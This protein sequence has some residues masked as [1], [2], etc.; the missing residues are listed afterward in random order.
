[1]IEAGATLPGVVAL[2][3]ASVPGLEPVSVCVAVGAAA[4]TEWV[5]QRRF[6]EE[7]PHF[8]GLLRIK[9]SA[10]LPAAVLAGLASKTGLGT[11]GLAWF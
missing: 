6:F 7:T 11:L 10:L 1:M 4:G 3:S 2:G 8:T 5:S 9:A